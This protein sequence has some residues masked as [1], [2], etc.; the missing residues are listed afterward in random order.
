MT[1]DFHLCGASG[2]SSDRLRARVSLR[3]DTG[4]LA[5]ATKMSFERTALGGR[6]RDFEWSSPRRQMWIDG[7]CLTADWG[8]RV[9]NRGVAPKPA[10]R[11]SLG[12][13]DDKCPFEAGH[14]LAL[15]W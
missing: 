12:V 3:L 14:G 6:Q 2:N 4:D 9:G 5:F 13:E 7:A 1:V 11:H 10:V 8:L 15:V